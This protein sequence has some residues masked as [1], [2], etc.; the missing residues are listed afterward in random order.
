MSD[1][2]YLNICEQLHDLHW[3][4]CVQWFLVNEPLLDKQHEHRLLLLRKYV[5]RCN[6][7]ITTNWDVMR[8]TPFDEQALKIRR[9]FNCGVNILNL[10][11]YEAKFVEPYK[12]LVKYIC[13]AGWA[14]YSPHHVWGK[15]RRDARVLSASDMSAPVDLHS[16]SGTFQ[17]GERGK[18]YKTPA[19]QCARPMRHLVIAW[20]GSIPVCCATNPARAESLGD[21]NHESLL[22]IW[23]GRKFF[24]YRHRLQRGIRTESCSGCDERAA[25]PTAIRRVEL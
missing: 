17:L 2:L 6:I 22:E 7:H 24:E 15:Q 25:Y 1:E 4:G 13:D 8:R 12:K 19:A 21:A 23:S 9:L 20:D 18:Q 3:D 11:A 16:W 5:P 14:T 10:N